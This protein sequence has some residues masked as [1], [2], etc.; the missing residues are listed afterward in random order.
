MVRS[1]EGKGTANYHSPLRAR[2]AAETRRSIVDA[3]LFLF[4]E[5]GWAA[6]ALP[7][8]AKRAGVSVDTI[9]STFGTK[10]A[11]LMAVVHVAI[12]GDD[13]DDP[14]VD[15]ADFAQFSRG[16]R[17]ERLRTGVRY[18]M[19]VY[20]RSIP[21]LETLREAAA[22]D[23]TARERLSRYDHDRRD[24][25]AAGVTLIVGHEPSED[26][27]DAFWAL[28]SPEVYRYLIVGRAWSAQKVE[29]WFVDMLKVAIARET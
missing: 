19:G 20:E 29:D 28:I 3:A 8:I 18:T 24:L 26:L 4:A 27:I 10:S 21:I 22:S 23:D 16:R 6:T 17:H 1:G 5:Q 12:V 7:A 9:Y 2:H 15:R 13:D 25:I 11:L 14:M